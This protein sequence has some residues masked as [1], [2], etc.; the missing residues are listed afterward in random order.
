M[1]IARK[2]LL[3]K[4]TGVYDRLEG[5]TGTTVNSDNFLNMTKNMSDNEFFDYIHGILADPKKHLYFE[6][7]VFER[8]PRWEE[9]EE[10]AKFLNLEL[11]DYVAFPHLSSDPSKPVYTINKIFVGWIN[12]RRVQ[13]V[14]NKKNSIPTGIDKRSSL[15]GQVSGESKAARVSDLEMFALVCHGVDNLTKEY[16]GPRAGDLVAKEEMLHQI[17]TTGSV[18]LKDLPNKRSNRVALNTA[19][20]YLLGGGMESDLITKEGYILQRTFEKQYEGA[21]GLTRK[22]GS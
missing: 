9:V 18:S 4:I 15:T 1:H 10:T 11:F 3:D 19:N 22:E 2:E 12:M 13:Q 6:I 14:V 16:F 7:E 17:A 5:H 21:K 20:V 8:E